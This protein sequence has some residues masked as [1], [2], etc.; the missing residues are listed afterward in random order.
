MATLQEMKIYDEDQGQR[1]DIHL[2][3]IFKDVRNPPKV[4]PSMLADQ[5][6]RAKPVG[7][8]YFF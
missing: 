7:Q 6:L 2:D 1:E 5:V 3:D 8:S 4:A